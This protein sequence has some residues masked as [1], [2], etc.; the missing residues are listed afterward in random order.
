VN[1][2]EIIS[3]PTREKSPEELRQDLKRKEIRSPKDYLTVTYSLDYKVLSGKDVINGKIYNSATIA[4]F[5]DVHLIVT[6]LT[7]TDSEI[8]SEEYVVYKYVYSGGSTAFQIKTNS[9]SS[10]KKIAVNISSATGE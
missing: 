3:E 10:T 8:G 9:P 4:T 1:N 5:K 2:N 7:G 6:Y